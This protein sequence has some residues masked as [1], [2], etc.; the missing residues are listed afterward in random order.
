[1]ARAHRAFRARAGQKP[2]RERVPGIEE[3]RPVR[4]TDTFLSGIGVFLPE[5]VSVAQAVQQGL[6]PA[7][8]VERFGWTGSAIA[9]D[10]PA[11]EMA[12]RACRQ[13]LERSGRDPL[14]M[15]LLLY[16]DCWHQGP[17]GWQPQT[18]LQHHLVG[19]DLLAAEVRQGCNGMLASLQLA[20]SYLSADP[21]RE[22][23]LLVSSDNFG[24]PLLD[25]WNPGP[26]FIASDAAAAMVLTREPGFAQ[27]LSIN[28]TTIAEVEEIHRCG[29]PLFPPG[30]TVGRVVDFTARLEAFQKKQREEGAGTEIAMKFHTNTQG[31]VKKTLAEAGVEL[32]DIAK[33]VITNSAKEQAEVQFMG[34]LGLPLEK[35]SWDYGRT[36]GHMGASDHTVSLNHLFSTGQF[37]PGDYIL[38]I[39][40]AP[41]ITYSCAVFQ[42]L[43]TPSWAT[44]EDGA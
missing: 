9:G 8:D 19:G 41:G 30:A 21:E 36:V 22:A 18:Y 38:L 37:K 12:L 39:G 17:D 6:Y 40:L 7:E 34:V 13:A 42:A 27:L 14:S 32:N 26:G 35:S 44:S 31:C 1:V 23:A 2:A 5:T 33:V 24:T 29:E 4:V 20:A 28:T 11:P 3:A 43:E 16:C 10:I 25:R 15:D